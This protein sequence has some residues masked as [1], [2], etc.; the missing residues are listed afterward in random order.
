MSTYNVTITD[1]PLRA[2]VGEEGLARLL[3]RR[4]QLVCESTEYV[5][6]RDDHLDSKFVRF[7]QDDLKGGRI[8]ELTE[9]NS[10]TEKR[11]LGFF[12]Q[13]EKPVQFT[14]QQTTSPKL[15]KPPA[16]CNA[17]HPT[18]GS[19]VEWAPR[20][21]NKSDPAQSLEGHFTQLDVSSAEGK[22]VVRVD[23]RASIEILAVDASGMVLYRHDGLLLK[24]YAGANMCII[25]AIVFATGMH[26]T[27]LNINADKLLA[28]FKRF[29][30][31]SRRSAI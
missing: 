8:V 20:S 24:A 27:E 21:A 11:E 19:P 29:K 23:Q 6:T 4:P 7:I 31:T 1:S 16:H 10:T 15:T 2:Y 3:E 9:W 28:E 22:R 13:H 12:E 18:A 5:T 14:N 30:D 26:L 25:E 17:K